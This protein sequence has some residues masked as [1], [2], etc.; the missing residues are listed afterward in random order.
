MP[1]LH[2]PLGRQVEHPAQRIVVGKG[3]FVFGDLPEL[4]V[5][6]LDDVRRVYDLPNLHGV[7]EK[8]AQDFPI[9]LPALHTGGI[10]PAPLV[11][12]VFPVCCGLVQRHRR[13]DLLQSSHHLLDVLVAHKFAGAAGLVDNAALQTA[14]GIDSLDGLHHT[15]QAVGAE[16]INIHNPPAFEV[17]QH[18]QPEFAALV[19]ADPHAQDVL[20]AI[21]GDAQQP[22]RLSWS[23]SGDP[24]SPYSGW[25]P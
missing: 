4:A 13:V 16:Q 11:R 9:C 3:R 10:L 20:P 6:A 22:H 12:K 17:I 1:V 15:A 21:Q 25:R 5:Q 24:P 23:H 2:D 14:L 19:L 7:C 8:G 18:I